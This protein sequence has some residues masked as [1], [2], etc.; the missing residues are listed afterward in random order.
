M[1]FF[2]QIYYQHHKQNEVN[3]KLIKY[4]I[5]NDQNKKDSVIINR[6]ICFLYLCFN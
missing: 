4:I 1:K 2:N 5:D 3:M 6:I